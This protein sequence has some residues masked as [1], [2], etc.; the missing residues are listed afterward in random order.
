MSLIYPIQT[1]RLSLRPF[2]PADLD[3][4]LAY[5]S[6][7]DV[8]RYL[9]RGV[10]DRAG[11]EELLKNWMAATAITQEG[12]R[13]VLAVVPR[14]QRRVIGQ[15]TLKWRSQPH[16]Q[17]ELGY[18]LNPA[19]QGQGYATEAAGA[20]LGLGFREFGFHRISAACDAR[21]TPSYKLME[22]LGMRREA[23]FIGNEFFKGEWSDELVYAILQTEWAETQPKDGTSPSPADGDVPSLG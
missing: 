7:E 13:L 14:E 15:V 8:V 20:I 1:A 5:M 12:E 17:A 23:H 4:V 18:I 11:A 19:Y 9:Y 2:E 16:R 10:Q 21:N 6:R 22:R 3:D